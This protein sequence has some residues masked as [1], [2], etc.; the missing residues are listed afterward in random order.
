M[1]LSKLLVTR[2]QALWLKKYDEQLTT[3]EARLRLK[4]L[5][6]LVRLTSRPQ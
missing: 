4:E 1:A 2:F 5:V 6:E 3:K